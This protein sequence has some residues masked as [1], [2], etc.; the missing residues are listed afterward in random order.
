MPFTRVVNGWHLDIESQQVTDEGPIPFYRAEVEVWREVKAAL[1]FKGHTI[2][3]HA[4][5][6]EAERIADQMGADFAR[7]H[8]PEGD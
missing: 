2:A 3:R 1:A 8:D 5:R 7:A 6:D 4:T